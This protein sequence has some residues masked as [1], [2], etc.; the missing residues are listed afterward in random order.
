MENGKPTERLIRFV[1]YLKNTTRA[2]ESE[3]TVLDVRLVCR[4]QRLMEYADWPASELDLIEH[5]AAGYGDEA[6][7]AQVLSGTVQPT[8]IKADSW[9]DSP[10]P[11]AWT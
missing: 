10:S 1:E 8:P 4:G 2:S 9:L 7:L 3:L 11:Y 5:E 6:D